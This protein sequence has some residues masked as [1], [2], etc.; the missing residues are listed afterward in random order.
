MVLLDQ[1]LF[2]L[3]PGVVNWLVEAEW[4]GLASNWAPLARPITE[5]VS[6]TLQ[7]ATSAIRSA[8]EAVQNEDLDRRDANDAIMD[9]ES[10]FRH[11]MD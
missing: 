1:C 2:I 5:S 6:L 10:C 4:K 8:L 9:E 11:G 3:G 7:T